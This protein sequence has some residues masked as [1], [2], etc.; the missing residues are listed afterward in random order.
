MEHPLMPNRNGCRHRLWFRA[1]LALIVACG[2]PNV[3]FPHLNRTAIPFLL[4]IC[5]S[6]LLLSLLWTGIQGYRRTRREARM[7]SLPLKWE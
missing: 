7:R 6:V 3:A 5:Q 1:R 4:V 2:L